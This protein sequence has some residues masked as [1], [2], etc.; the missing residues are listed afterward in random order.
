MAGWECRGGTP[1]INARWFAI[2]LTPANS[3]WVYCRGEPYRVIAALELY[4]TLFGVIAF[5][6]G[7][8]QGDG[9]AVVTGSAVT[10]NKGNAYAT[11]RLMSTNIPS[12]P[13]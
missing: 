9:S 2:R 4:A 3:A 6:S 8:R 12:T 7:D 11:A 5:M 13:S 10:D 1:P